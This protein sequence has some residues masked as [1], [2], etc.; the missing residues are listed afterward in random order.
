MPQTSSLQAQCLAAEASHAKLSSQLQ[1][2]AGDKAAL[3][4]ANETLQQALMDKT[5]QAAQEAEAARQQQATHLAA[6]QAAHQ[7]AL[8]AAAATAA[9]AGDAHK[10][11]WLPAAPSCHSN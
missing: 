4:A 3:T 8:Q 9:Q 5:L 2:L 7:H 11:V 1:Q 6:L 10:Q